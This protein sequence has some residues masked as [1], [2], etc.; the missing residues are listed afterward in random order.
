[1]NYNLCLQH[2]LSEASEKQAPQPGCVRVVLQLLRRGEKVF[3]AP[4]RSFWQA[5]RR[6]S[7]SRSK[8]GR[9]CSAADG[10]MLISIAGSCTKL[11]RLLS[12][13]RTGKHS[14]QGYSSLVFCSWCF[15]SY[16][17]LLKSVCGEKKAVNC[18]M[19]TLVEWF[20]SHKHMFNLTKSFLTYYLLVCFKLTNI[21]LF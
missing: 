11:L 6:R 14:L 2:V 7:D 20:R 12:L 8:V 5:G 10:S 19:G 3:T 16:V 18:R 13:S 15:Y 4:H 17:N 21:C 1:M 9:D